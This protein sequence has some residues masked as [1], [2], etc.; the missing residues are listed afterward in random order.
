M[1]TIRVGRDR[2][3][4]DGNAWRGDDAQL[5]HLLEVLT[6]YERNS[7]SI[8]RFDVFGAEHVVREL[9]FA[10]ILEV[11]P[12]PPDSDADAGVVY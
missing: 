11:S 8:P 12:D 3:T 9:G 1:V 6:P 5:V 4:F 2:A 7:P 10:E